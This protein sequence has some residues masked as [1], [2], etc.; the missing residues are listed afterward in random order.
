MRWRNRLAGYC[1]AVFLNLVLLWGDVTPRSSSWS[2]SVG[3]PL[4]RLYGGPRI[5]LCADDANAGSQRAL[6]LGDSCEL[7]PHDGQQWLFPGT[8]LLLRPAQLAFCPN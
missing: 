3:V 5:V 7:S 8:R 1:V 2:V 6:L 4:V